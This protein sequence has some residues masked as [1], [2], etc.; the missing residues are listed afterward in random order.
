MVSIIIPV[1]N[2][3]AYLKKC[4]DSIRNQTYK[5]WEM[6]LVDDGS[7]DNS[8]SVCEAYQAEDERIRLVAQENM[9]QGIA[10][11]NG[12]S[13]ARGEYMMFVD[14]DDWVDTC[15]IEKLMN[16]LTV[17]NAD[18]AICNLHRTAFNEEE[19][20]SKYEEI[21]EEECLDR[22]KDDGY[23][24]EISTY[25]VA[26]LF[27]TELFRKTNFAFP[28]HYFEDVAAMPILYAYADRI[29]FI[30]EAYY[31]YRNREGSTVNSLEHLEDRVRCMYSLVKLFKSHNL[32]E[33]YYEEMERYIIRRIKVNANMVKK[34]L[35]RFRSAFAVS[36]SE[37]FQS[38]F[39][40]YKE[41]K[42][43]NVLTWGSFNLYSI[44]KAFMKSDRDEI[45]KEY[46]GFQSIISLMNKKNRELDY[47]MAT[48]QASF[49]QIGINNDFANKFLHKTVMEFSDIDYILI[50]FLEERHDVGRIGENYFTISDAFL[51]SK[52]DGM[53]EYEIISRFDEN[54]SLLW[55]DSCDRFIRLL[56]GYIKPEKIILVRLKLCEYYG[57]YEEKRLYGQID[58]IRK[59]NKL[60]DEYYDYFISRCPEA[61]VIDH[62]F[63]E[64]FY[65]TAQEFRH[66]CF[67]WHLRQ[68]TFTKIGTIIRER[69]GG[70]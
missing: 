34:V 15:I 49:R 22:G 48:H 41:E 46:Y 16:S 19:V 60:L 24:F 29:S 6:I 51:Q 13:M 1:Y 45:L 31:Y 57:N 12:I 25:P 21:F 40:E 27:K 61:I 17:N 54:T 42:K 3:Q 23:V 63:E 37:F 43:P 44:S 58:E 9:G 30:S 18:I 7:T 5:D 36:Q 47:T 59:T 11:N 10:R 20:V 70:A 56:K 33:K 35:N 55:K 68:G 50:D 28:E 64:E 14:S 4:L 67:P 53:A 39:G 32:F 65:F 38:Y 26:K 2:A 52:H 69:V 62:L 66:G 8:L